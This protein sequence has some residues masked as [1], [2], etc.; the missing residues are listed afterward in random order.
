MTYRYP[1][2]VV[3]ISEKMPSLFPEYDA[4]RREMKL[5]GRA[6]EIWGEAA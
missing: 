1:F 6:Y 3:R 5:A 2:N 4:L